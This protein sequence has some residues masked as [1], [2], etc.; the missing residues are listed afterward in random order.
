M[1]RGAR[2]CPNCR[3][4]NPGYRC[5]CVRCNRA[6]TVRERERRRELRRES[7]LRELNGKEPLDV[8]EVD[9]TVEPVESNAD[10]VV[11]AILAL[12]ALAMLVAL[13]APVL[14]W[15]L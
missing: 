9:E 3:A 2:A 6:L 15:S 8:P 13:A 14:G 11:L 5:A 12:G 7:E 1:R 4:K 10:L